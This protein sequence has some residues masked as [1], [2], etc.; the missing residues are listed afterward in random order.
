ME[1]D[2]I[3]STFLVNCDT[4]QG[5]KRYILQC[6][7]KDIFK[8]IEGL[9]GNITSVTEFLREK[10]ICNEGNPERETLTLVKSIDGRRYVTDPGWK[11]LESISFCGGYH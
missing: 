5:R 6:M 8:N 4:K 1:A 10:I 9:M 3:N 2:G 11:F 7:N